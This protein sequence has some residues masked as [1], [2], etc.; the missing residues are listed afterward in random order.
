MPPGPTD[1][2]YQFTMYFLGVGYF[3]V[4]LYLIYRCIR[5]RFEE[6]E[7]LNKHKGEDDEYD[8]VGA[9]G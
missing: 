5:K 1:A 3:L 9:D 4:M 8:V 6:I 2:E 7:V